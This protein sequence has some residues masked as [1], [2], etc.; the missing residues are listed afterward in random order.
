MKRQTGKPSFVSTRV[1]LG[2]VLAVVGTTFSA[3]AQDKKQDTAPEIAFTVSLPK[4]H[5]HMLDVEMTIKH[6][7]GDAVANEEVLVL[8]VWTPGS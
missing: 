6:G 3:A 5:T 7:P 4:P 1:L 8:P 2:V